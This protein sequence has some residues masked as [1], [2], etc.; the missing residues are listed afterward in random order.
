MF[1]VIEINCILGIKKDMNAIEILI[2]CLIFILLFWNAIQL[3]LANKGK[4]TSKYF[5]LNAKL[6]FIIATGSL[7]ILLITYLG[8]DSKEEILKRSDPIINNAVHKKIAEVD[9]VIDSK[10]ILK[11]G[12]YIVND[13]VF[14]EGK[15]YRF[16]ELLTID[17]KHLPEFA[18]KPKLIIITNTGENLRIKDVTSKYFILSHPIKKANYIEFQEDNPEYP[19]ELKFDVWIAD[20]EIE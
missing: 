8:W 19:K 17:N 6:N 11:I 14:K 16:T 7:A 4:R 1:F 12:T 5:E 2:L 9:S 20:Y 10:N 18:N 13:L 15:Q 3:T